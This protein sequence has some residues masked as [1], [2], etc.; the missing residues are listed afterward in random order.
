MVMSQAAQR[1]TPVDT[2]RLF[3]TAP[4]Q[5]TM[6]LPEFVRKKKRDDHQRYYQKRAQNQMLDHD[7]LQIFRDLPVS[8]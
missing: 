8:L 6:L 1:M 2:S 4:S 5:L 7:S 3:D